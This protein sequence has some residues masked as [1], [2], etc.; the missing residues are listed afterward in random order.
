MKFKKFKKEEHKVIK[1]TLATRRETEMFSNG[2]MFF[3]VNGSEKLNF[4][5]REYQL[6]LKARENQKNRSLRLVK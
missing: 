1:A 6:Y 3:E 2:K 4:H 5:E